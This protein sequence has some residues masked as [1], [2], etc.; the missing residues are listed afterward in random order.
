LCR[1]REPALTPLSPGYNG[2]VRCGAWQ[3]AARFSWI[4][5][6]TQA[7]QAANLYDVTLGLN[8]F[9]NPNMKFQWNFDYAFRNFVGDTSDGPIYG[10]SFRFAMDF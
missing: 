3:V 8:W 7:F 2:R 4:D 5:L 10:F 9:L 6:D 1:R